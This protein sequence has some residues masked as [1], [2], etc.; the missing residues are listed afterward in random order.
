MRLIAIELFTHRASGGLETLDPT[1]GRAVSGG[2]LSSQCTLGQVFRYLLG[3]SDLL[4]AS[5]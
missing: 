1:A 3:P 4:P 2:L 5:G